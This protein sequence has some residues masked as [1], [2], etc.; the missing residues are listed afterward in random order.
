MRIKVGNKYY[1]LRKDAELDWMMVGAV[2]CALA[3]FPAIQL[4]CKLVV[5]FA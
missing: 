1:K 5:L 4:F 2:I 3:F